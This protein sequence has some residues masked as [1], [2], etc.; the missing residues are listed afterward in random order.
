[1]CTFTQWLHMYKVY[2]L[3]NFTKKSKNKKQ[4]NN[5]KKQMTPQIAGM[6][7]SP[8]TLGKGILTGRADIKQLITVICKN[9]PLWELIMT[10]RRMLPWLVIICDLI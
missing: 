5:K 6:L 3:I 4:I 10:E 7:Y 2:S 8:D 1:M 9:F